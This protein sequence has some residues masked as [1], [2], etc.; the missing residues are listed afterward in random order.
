MRG[1]L[2][3][4]GIARRSARIPVPEAGEETTGD[5]PGYWL[6]PR[7]WI[8]EGYRLLAILVTGLELEGYRGA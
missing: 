6:P 4:R 5:G 8:I 2:L 1:L 7:G 3:G